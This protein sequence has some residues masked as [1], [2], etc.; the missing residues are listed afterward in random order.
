[1]KIFVG[2]AFSNTKFLS[3]SF[4]WFFAD[5]HLEFL[6]MKGHCEWFLTRQ[7]L[8]VSLLFYLYRDDLCQNRKS[9]IYCY[10]PKSTLR[11]STLCRVIDWIGYN[12]P[13]HLSWHVRTTS[14][15]CC[16]YILQNIPW[17]FIQV[18]GD[19]WKFYFSFGKIHKSR[20][21]VIK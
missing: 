6:V 4:I 7:K 13:T 3:L 17:K 2:N 12:K 21:I 9:W 8:R 1:M 15:N 11:L 16:S 19:R 5:Y 18:N 14:Y 20:V 10:M